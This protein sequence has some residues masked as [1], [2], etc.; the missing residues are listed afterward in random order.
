M[1][2]T[3]EEIEAAEGLALLRT[4]PV[5]FAAGQVLPHHQYQHQYQQP[6]YGLPYIHYQQ[7]P[8]PAAFNRPLNPTAPPFVPGSMAPPPPPP[9]ANLPRGGHFGIMRPVRHTCNR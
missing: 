1:A 3:K 9:R 2:P 6:M 7:A 5:N 8:P 4:Y